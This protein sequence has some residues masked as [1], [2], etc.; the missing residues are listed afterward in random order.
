MGV[1]VPCDGFVNAFLL[2][3]DRWVWKWLFTIE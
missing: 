3:E 1:S 2:G